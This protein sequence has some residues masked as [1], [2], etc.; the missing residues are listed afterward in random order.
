MLSPETIRSL[1]PWL[2]GL[3]LIAAALLPVFGR[4]AKSAQVDRTR[5][6][7]AP[8]GIDGSRC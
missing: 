7:L 3:P 1:L 6:G 2:I 8:P 4:T 5:G